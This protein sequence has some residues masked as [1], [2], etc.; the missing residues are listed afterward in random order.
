MFADSLRLSTL[1]AAEEALFARDYLQHFSEEESKPACVGEPVFLPSRR[2]TWG[3][4]LVH[5][6]M[7]APEEVRE[8]ANYLHE[9]GFTVY[10]PRMAGHGTSA[11]DLADRHAEEWIASVERGRRI[12]ECCCTHIVIAGFS[13]GGAVALQCVIRQ[14][15]AFE[16][17]ISVSAPLRFKSFAAH[18]A[19]PVHFA[20]NLMETLGLP[21]CRKPFVTNHA[22]N[23]DINYLRC[24]VSSIVQ[25]KQLMHGV[26]RRLSTVRIPALI[27]HAVH[28]PKVDVRG[29]R[30]LYRLLG[31][32]AKRYR[33]IH[34]HRH[35]IV[36]GDIAREVFAETGD[37]LAGI[38]ARVDQ[39]RAAATATPPP[40]AEPPATAPASW[41]GS[42]GTAWPLR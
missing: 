13:T 22:D 14:P 30:E 37:F 7:A 15:D 41:V 16:A 25:I 34:F 23:P 33:E 28:D 42:A 18:F 11:N 35:G 4:L 3:V 6:L 32:T 29:G 5:G 10:A 9:Q 12:L 20:N 21:A 17:V 39:A 8:W 1:L 31:S 2:T 26:K 36:R 38:T 40:R 27:I 24:P 19:A